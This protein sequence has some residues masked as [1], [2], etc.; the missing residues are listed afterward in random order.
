LQPGVIFCVVIAD[1]S[2][3]KQ[4]EHLLTSQLKRW[5]F[6]IKIVMSGSRNIAIARNVSLLNAVG[7]YLAFIDDDETADEDWLFNYVTLA[8][9]S[10][11]DAIFGPVDALYPKESCQWICK[12]EPFMKRT[13]RSGDIV[14]TGSTCNAFVKKSVVDKFKLHFR[15]NLGQ[16]GGED[17]AFFYELSKHGA[18]LIASDNA[19]VYELV[20]K[21]RLTISHL[22]RRYIR[23][24]Q[25]YANIFFSSRNISF[26]IVIYS[27]ALIKTIGL[28][29]VISFF[30]L[31]RKDVA[32]KYAFKLWLNFGKLRNLLN[33]L[34]FNLYGERR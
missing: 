1:D 23:G 2:L 8:R 9:S 7:D 34:T 10:K 19:K 15:P 14:V 17:T 13:G 24:G 31:F 20:P 11:A 26:K 12:A 33:V 21:E 16:S 4:V 29:F 25:T 30:C 28:F 22:S 6:S 32:L 5:S 3:D 18:T 27:W